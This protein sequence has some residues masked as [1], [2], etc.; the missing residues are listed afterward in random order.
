MTCYIFSHHVLHVTSSVIT[1]DMLHLQ[2]SRFCCY[3]FPRLYR[4][5]ADPLA[6]L[7][8]FFSVIHSYF[9]LG[10]GVWPPQIV[11]PF[12]LFA[13][14]SLHHSLYAITY[15]G[16]QGVLGGCYGTFG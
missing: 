12:R 1:F 8:P 4:H 11:S 2:S 14:L 10:Q 9:D 15:C 13:S 3:V 16:S 7:L 6:V 5:K